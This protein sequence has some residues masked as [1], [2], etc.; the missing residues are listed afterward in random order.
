[1]EL[2]ADA[3]RRGFGAPAV[4]DDVSAA[5][6]YLRLSRVA[7]PGERLLVVSRISQ[8]FVALRGTVLRVEPR[9]EG[10]GLAV[11][12]AQYKIFPPL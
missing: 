2:D 11:S 8:A 5:G 4:L 12:I 9:E 6:F 3:G 10:C 1:M 7:A